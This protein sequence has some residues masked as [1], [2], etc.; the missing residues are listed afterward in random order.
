[1]LCK[2]K[3]YLWRIETGNTI[4]YSTDASSWTTVGTF[5]P[6]TEMVLAMAGMN[7]CMYFTTAQ[8]LW[9][10]AEG[11]FI[12]FVAEWN[13]SDYPSKGRYL[14]N[15]G[16]A[17]YALV[18]EQTIWRIDSGHQIM[19]IMADNAAFIGRGA[20]PVAIGVVKDYLCVAM[21]HGDTELL[22]YD[23]Y[24]YR[25]SGWHF[26]AAVP[27]TNPVIGILWDKTQKTVIVQIAGDTSYYYKIGNLFTSYDY[28]SLANF[29]P[30][31]WIEY[32]RNRGGKP[33]I[34]KEWEAV[35][36]DIKLQP[37][38]AIEIYGKYDGQTTL[39]WQKIYPLNGDDPTYTNTTWE[40]VLQAR[41]TTGTDF[42]RVASKW[43]KIGIRL[44]TQNAA[45]TPVLSAVSL[46]YLPSVTDRWQWNLAIPVQDDMPLEDGSLATYTV[47][48]QRA[49]L[50]S[51]IQ[52][53]TLIYFEDIDGRVYG[54]KVLSGTNSPLEYDPNSANIGTYKDEY[55]E[56][57]QITL[58][59]FEEVTA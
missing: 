2:Y 3:G 35:F 51:L 56:M 42:G 14:S 26:L 41:I 45:Y 24:L 9:R 49:H 33:T 28:A 6:T 36:A 32:D 57:Y 19:N 15:I 50:E 31:G 40:D 27:T 5:Y 22:G 46:Q 47:A 39:G 7:N 11:D 59:Q 43:A 20:K 48:Q 17:L 30:E 34:A 44:S 16:D 1:M 12:E 37:Y 58:Q 23:L 55:P 4:Y 54:C 38:T 52:S 29:E 13:G 21:K 53:E 18:D 8:G 10:V 25:N